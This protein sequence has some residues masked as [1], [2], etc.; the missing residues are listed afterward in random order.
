MRQEIRKLA[1]GDRHPHGH[2]FQVL[3][4]NG[5]EVHTPPIIWMCPLPSDSRTLNLCSFLHR[6][7][8]SRRCRRLRLR[9]PLDLAADLELADLG[10]HVA[11]Q[12][13]CHDAAGDGGQ[14]R[15]VARPLALPP[16]LRS[17]RAG[18]RS[19]IGPTWVCWRWSN[20]LGL[21]VLLYQHRVDDREDRK[22]SVNGQHARSLRQ[23]IQDVQLTQHSP[24]CSPGVVDGL[25]LAAFDSLAS[26]GRHRDRAAARHGVAPQL[27]PGAET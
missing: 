25:I 23:R 11:R 12:R 18:N 8:R 20:C 26:G 16:H 24:Q 4:R 27:C 14:G 6:G 5:R 2:L 19:I 3:H 13:R 22:L 10:Q 17:S 1:H 21:R 7:G 9:G 15:L